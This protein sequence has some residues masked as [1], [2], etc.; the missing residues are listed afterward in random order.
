VEVLTENTK[1]KN[2]V[3]MFV[4]LDEISVLNPVPV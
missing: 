3:G 4:I 1:K 2:A